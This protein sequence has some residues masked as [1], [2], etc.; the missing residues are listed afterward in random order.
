MMRETDASIERAAMDL[1]EE[2]IKRKPADREG[3]V[4]SFADVSE[5]IRTRALKLL[6]FEQMHDNSIRT[7]AASDDMEE[8]GPPPKKIGAYQ[9]LRLI[10]RGG[11]GNVYLAE[12]AAKDFD[13]IVAIKVIKQRLINPE[14]VERFRRERQILADLSHSH[15]ARLYDGGETADGAPYF[16]MEYVDGAPLHHWLQRNRPS[17]DQALAVFSQICDAVAFAHQHLVIHRDLTPPNIL[18]DKNDQAKL[19]DFG[20]ARPEDDVSGNDAPSGLS[21]TPGFASPERSSENAATVLSDIYSLGKLLEVLTVQTSDDELASIIHK[22]IANNPT[23]RYQSVNE[24]LADVENYKSNKPIS[25]LSDSKRYVLRKFVGRQKLLVLL[26]CL[27][28]VGLVVALI[29]TAIAYRQAEEARAK[30]ES[31]YIDTRDIASVMMF[32]VFD[33]VSKL[34]GNTNARM[35]IAQNAQHYLEALAAEPESPL[36]VRLAAG[37]GFSRLASVTG[38]LAAGNIGKLTE[39]LALFEQARE[40]LESVYVEAPGDDVRLALADV[41]VSLARDKLLTYV[42]TETAVDHA[43]RAVFLLREI[44]KP[45]VD[46]AALLG[47]SFRYLGDARGCCNDDPEGGL[48]AIEAGLT[49][50]HSQTAKVRDSLSVRRAYNDLTNLRAGF[51]YFFGEKKKALELFEKTL[52]A[53]TELIQLFGRNPEDLGLLTTIA[54]NFSRTLLATGDVSRAE[55]IITPVWQELLQAYDADP[56]DNSLGRSVSILALLRAE[57]SA[58]NGSHGVASDFLNQGVELAVKMEDVTDISSGETMRFASRLNDAAV[59]ANILGETTLACQYAIKSLAIMQ[60]YLREGRLPQTA[61]RYR[62]E[63]MME[64]FRDCK[65]S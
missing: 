5:A 35:I 59:A 14:I 51:H 37:R 7:G 22:A 17:R 2:A 4:K 52:V 6:L 43:E 42:D 23:E 32:D 18:L 1:L 45:S 29:V 63:P 57:I 49:N 62:L 53:Q 36:N 56:L 11:M 12:R 64:R 8:D 30:A 54:T 16:V 38:S 33:E 41:H 60:Q 21:F 65:E 44:E 9:I 15:I 50:T 48:K 24:L 31:R 47:R 10:G 27:F 61:K 39:G 46:K 55:Q 3:F 19:I 13:Q 58:T 28:T 25:T 26:T 20:I 34:S 40:F